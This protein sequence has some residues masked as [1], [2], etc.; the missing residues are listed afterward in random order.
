MK[1]NFT[2]QRE[3]SLRIM[4]MSMLGLV[5]LTV[6]VFALDL[7]SVGR[8]ESRIGLLSNTTEGSGNLVHMERIS[9]GI[10]Q[11]FNYLGFNY[12]LSGGGLIRGSSY[13]GM[14]E[15]VPEFQAKAQIQPFHK[16]IIEMFS[17]SQLSNPMQIAED[18]IQYKEQVSG[19]QF[20]SS[21]PNNGR[22]LVA[23]G[24]RNS[25]RDTNTIDHQFAKLH[26]EQKLMG[27]QFRFSGEKDLINY[28]VT[29]GDDDRS[30][31]SIQWYGSPL[32]GLNWTAINSVYNYGSDAYWRVYQRTKYQLSHRSAVWA[33]FN[34]QQISYRGSTLNTQDYDV[35]YRW[36]KRDALAFQLLSEGSKVKP[37]A[38]DPQY[39]WRAYLAGIQWHFGHQTSTMGVLQFG[40]KESYR[41]G[42][43]LDMRYELEER[44][45][46]IQSRKLRVGFSDHS[47]GEIFVGLDGISED[48]RYDIDHRLDLTVDLWPGKKAQ[49]ANTFRLL[50]HLGIDL[51][52]SEDTLRNAIT[53]NIQFKYIKRRLRVSLDHLTVM[54]FG[55]QNDLRL[56]L[57]TRFT[58]RMSPGSSFNLISMYRYQSEIY[59]DYLWLNSFIKV[60]MHYFDWALEV[61]TQGRPETMLD[62]NFSLWMRFMRQL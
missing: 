62:E 4:M 29:G 41:F 11:Q 39:H 33:H 40:Y 52:F 28:N 1:L 9:W 14:T 13:I 49:V 50:N 60:N 16:T 45:P 37:L 5:I 12:N 17:Y 19:L 38:G 36:K 22:L 35:D 59:P 8:V 15:F 20:R 47:D 30:N 18:S 6:Q 21:L 56:H 54:D 57:N 7:S 55:E 3:S 32:K 53:H 2:Y 10:Q 58:Y 26:L 46:L 48:P 24:F 31:M 43:G 42:S 23:Y 34:N 61:Q 51:D 27:L 44:F 25:K